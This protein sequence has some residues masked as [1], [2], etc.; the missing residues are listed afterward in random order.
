MIKGSKWWADCV[1]DKLGDGYTRA[2]L[3]AIDNGDHY[4]EWITVVDGD[5]E[6]EIVRAPLAIGTHDDHVFL[7]GVSAEACDMITRALEARGLD[8][9]LATPALW[10]LASADPRQVQIGPHTLPQLIGQENGA[11]GMTKSAAK[12]H[13]DAL[14]RDRPES[15]SFMAC[16]IKTYVLHPYAADP[17]DHVRDGY[18]CEYG[19]RLAGRV[20]WGS[21]A[22]TGSGYVVQPAQWAHAYREFWDYSMGVILVKKAARFR[23]EA[24]NL[25]ELALAGAD[26]PRVAPFGPVPYL[27]S[28]EC[29]PGLEALS[30]PDTQ[31][32]PPS[33]PSV[34]HPTLQRGSKGSAVAEWQRVLMAAG[35]SLAPWNDDGSFGKLTHN[36]TVG[37]QHERGLEGTGVV[38]ADTW[39]AIGTLP[40][41]RD[42]PDAGI[43]AI[44]PCRN[45]TPANRT[46]VDNIVVHTIEAVEASTTADRTAAWGAGPNAPRASWHACFDDDSTIECVPQEHVAWAAPGLN[47]RGIQ[48]EHAGFARQTP[49]QWFDPFSRRMLKRSALY[50]AAACKRWDIPV[51]F[52]DAE[53]LMRGERGITTHYQVT[54]GPGKGRTTHVDPGKGFPMSTYLDMI[55]EAMA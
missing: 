31:P 49:E 53:G 23:G 2:I 3:E 45:F 27:R 15:C 51:R 17:S 22:A 4:L 34:S 5:F 39:A 29:R 41:E 30:G 1:P 52:V 43:T 28:P 11:A 46:T 42:E 18:G 40:I 54:K 47:R 10:D 50:A 38:D 20:G 44:V 35:F 19:W 21:K 32:S 8:V 55:K 37:W 26:S 14:A 25:A 33:A 16:A 12:A 48:L 13:A 6:F 7:L 36:A 9:M 24:A